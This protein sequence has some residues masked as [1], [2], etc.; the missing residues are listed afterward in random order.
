VRFPVHFSPSLPRVFPCAVITELPYTRPEPH[1]LT[2]RLRLQWLRVRAQNCQLRR[3]SHSPDPAHVEP[4]VP[5]TRNI[6][7]DSQ[8]TVATSVI[9]VDRRGE[10]NVPKRYL[11]DTEWYTDKYLGEGYYVT[12]PDKDET[13]CTVDFNFDTLQWGL[14]EPVDGRYQITRPIPVKY[15]L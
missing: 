15:G 10:R 4:N 12:D 2:E 7:S 8:S 5:S 9:F 6:N 3:V 13:F 1:L 11:K 14:T